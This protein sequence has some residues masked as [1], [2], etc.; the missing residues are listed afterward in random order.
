[1]CWFI[2]IQIV[3]NWAGQAVL[4]AMEKLGPK[5]QESIRK[6]SDVRLVANLT[7]AGLIQDEL[8]GMDRPTML[9][10]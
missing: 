3:I 5:E 6:L 1:M 4:I 9:K 10:K 7:K 8:E 2:R